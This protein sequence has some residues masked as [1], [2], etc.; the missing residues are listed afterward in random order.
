TPQVGGTGDAT[1]IEASSAADTPV[2][3]LPSG[4]IRD[5]VAPKTSS[6]ANSPVSLPP[7]SRAGDAGTVA[8][9]VPTMPELSPPTGGIRFDAVSAAPE[10]SS[11][12]GDARDATIVEVSPALGGAP[13]D[14][15]AEELPTP[16]IPSFADEQHP[17]RGPE[18]ET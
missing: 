7:S 2:S 15:T 14:G 1:A 16:A 18:T 9:P 8:S 6:V 3:S 10:V 11:Q 13:P 5:A 12:S 4:G 17:E